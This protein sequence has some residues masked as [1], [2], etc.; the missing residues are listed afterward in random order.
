[1]I[2]LVELVGDRDRL[3][4]SGDLP[5]IDREGIILNTS[6]SGIFGAGFSVKLIEPAGKIGGREGVVSV[7]V[8]QVVLALEIWDIGSGVAVQVSRVRKLFG[9]MFNRHWVQFRY[10]SDLSGPRWMWLKLAQQIQFSP[11]HDWE[12]DGHATAVITANALEPRYESRPL[13][14]EITTSTD[15]ETVWFPVWNPTDQESWP[16]WSLIPAS[17]GSSFT[18][19]DFSFDQEQDVDRSWT[20]GMHAARTIAIPSIEVPWNVMPVRSGMDPYVA[21]DLSNAAGQ[22]GGLFPLYSVPAY[23]GRKSDPVLLPVTAG[24]AGS[25]IRLSLRRFWSAESGLE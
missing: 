25:T 9:T 10:T 1:M 13:E 19:P 4:I 12:E 23:T 22:M 16:T 21:A 7:P 8:M 5:E 6:P 18:I 24:K 11:E 14:L 20:V 17:G 3:T 15:A 2:S